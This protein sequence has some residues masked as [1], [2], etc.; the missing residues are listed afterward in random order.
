[1]QNLI[2]NRPSPKGEGMGVRWL[3][4]IA[5][6]GIIISCFMHW[7]Y[8]PDLNKYFTGFFSEKK[9]Y[10]RPGYFLCLMAFFSL[11]LHLLSIQ[12][13]KWINVLIAALITS[14]AVK[15]YFLFTGAYAGIEPLK[16]PGIYLMLTMSLINMALTVFRPNRSAIQ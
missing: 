8:H 2:P 3:A 5:C 7:T 11:I 6:M 9:Y 13:I 4:V 10:G 16:K 12:R 1:M 14:Y 15:T